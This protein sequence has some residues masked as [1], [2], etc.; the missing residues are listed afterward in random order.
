MGRDCR[1]K[2]AVVGD[3][4]GWD[5]FVTVINCGSLCSSGSVLCGMKGNGVW[6]DRRYVGVSESFI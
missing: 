2:D 6:S 1:D 5:E 4:E 3:G